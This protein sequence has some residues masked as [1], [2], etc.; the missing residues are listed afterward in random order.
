MAPR[1]PSKMKRGMDASHRIFGI[2][3]SGSLSVVDQ[4]SMTNLSSRV[5]LKPSPPF[6]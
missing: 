5:L 3:L 2:L 6:L 4:N 1:I